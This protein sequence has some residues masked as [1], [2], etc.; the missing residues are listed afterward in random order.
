[1]HRFSRWFSGLV[2]VLVF[3]GGL[4]FS[5]FNTTPVSLSLGQF[6]S[7]GRPVSLWIIG[8]FVL[9]GSM[10]L[11]VGLGLLFRNRRLH[12]EIRRLELALEAS[13]T[14]LHNLR[15]HSYKDYD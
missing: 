4:I 11:L 14:E 5:Y 13:R 3:V 7:V 1:M 10:G 15:T 6:E 9:G 8:G 2:L 12:A